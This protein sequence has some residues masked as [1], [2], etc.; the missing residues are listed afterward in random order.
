MSQPAGVFVAESGPSR[1]H[2]RI[3]DADRLLIRAAS[4]TVT[5]VLC[6]GMALKV[7]PHVYAYRPLLRRI[8]RG[9]F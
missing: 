6:P 2:R 4:S 7:A 8:A 5:L 3:V 1:H 9:A